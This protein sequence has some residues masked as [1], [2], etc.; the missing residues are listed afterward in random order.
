DGGVRQV[1]GI[2][3]PTLALDAAALHEPLALTFDEAY[4][5]L[6]RLPRMYLEPD[7]SLLWVG[8]SAGRRWQLDGQLQDRGD[9]LD[10]IELKGTCSDEA[11]DAFL[12]A[13]GW[14]AQQVVFH[15]VAEGVFLAEPAARKL[16]VNG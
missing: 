7:G 3:L 8:E 4:A 1:Q 10:Y 12:T 2:E 16:L 9:R 15:L 5:A 14:P 11:F 13:L 6:E